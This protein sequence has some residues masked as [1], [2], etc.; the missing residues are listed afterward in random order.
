MADEVRARASSW[1]SL[2]GEGGGGLPHTLSKCAGWYLRGHALVCV[3]RPNQTGLEL[4]QRLFQCTSG[5][6]LC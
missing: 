2:P 5:T 3:V 6:Y 4:L 1:L